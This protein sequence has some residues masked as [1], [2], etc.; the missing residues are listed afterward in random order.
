MKLMYLIL[1]FGTLCTSLSPS[2]TLSKANSLAKAGKTVRKFIKGVSEY[3]SG[4]KPSSKSKTSTKGS[5]KPRANNKNKRHSPKKNVKKIKN[6]PQT[7]SQTTSDSESGGFKNFVGQLAI[8]GVGGGGLSMLQ[9]LNTDNSE[10][11]YEYEYVTVSPT[12]DEIQ[13]PTQVREYV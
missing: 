5:K 2:K 7:S 1:G 11:E 8:A 3:V 9:G 4:K 13:V 10:Y 12:T 6:R